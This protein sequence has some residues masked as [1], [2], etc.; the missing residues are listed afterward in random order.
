MRLLSAVLFTSLLA[1]GL[2]GTAVEKRTPWGGV[3][4]WM[5][6]LCDYP[7]GSLN[8]LAA[9]GTDLVVIDLSRDGAGDDFTAS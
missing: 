8:A 1:A 9:C 4:S 3:R 6:Q 7:G 5:Y 2:Q